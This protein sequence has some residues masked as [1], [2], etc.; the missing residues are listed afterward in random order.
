M[1]LTPGPLPGTEDL[2]QGF[3]QR[4]GFLAAAA[5]QLER[6]QVHPTV[7]QPPVERKFG[8]DL[9]GHAPPVAQCCQANLLKID[10]EVGIQQDVDA[11]SVFGAHWLNHTRL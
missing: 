5:I 10:Q 2:R 4:T 11:A 8:L 6:Q 1:L 9:V 3:D 7:Q